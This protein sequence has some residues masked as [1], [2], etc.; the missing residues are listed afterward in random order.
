MI[1]MRYYYA[2]GSEKKILIEFF[3]S[4]DEKEKKLTQVLKFE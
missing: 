4:L 3:H 1:I 2:K